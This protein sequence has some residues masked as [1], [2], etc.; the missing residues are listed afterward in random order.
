MWFICWSYYCF[1]WFKLLI[2]NLKVSLRGYIVRVNEGMKI[3]IVILWF[4]LWLWNKK[5]NGNIRKLK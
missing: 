5:K 4:Y 3:I 2:R 1:F